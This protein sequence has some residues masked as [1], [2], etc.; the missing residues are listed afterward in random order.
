MHLNDGTGGK[1]GNLVL[2]RPADVGVKFDDCGSN[3][4]ITQTPQNTDTSIGSVGGAAAD[5]YLYFSSGNIVH[6]A[7]PALTASPSCGVAN[8]GAMSVIE[9][10]PLLTQPDAD[11]AN[12]DPRP[13]CDSPAYTGDVEDPRRDAASLAFYDEAN[14]KGAFGNFNWLYGWSAISFA[15]TAPFECEGGDIVGLVITP[16]QL[17]PTIIDNTV[18]VNQT[19]TVYVSAPPAAPGTIMGTGSNGAA[20]ADGD[21]PGWGIG[22]FV[23]LAFLALCVGCTLFLVVQRERVGKPI[24]KPLKE[25]VASATKSSTTG[26]SNAEIKGQTNV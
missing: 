17:P 13:A 2:T 8:T 18:Y 9:S 16:D 24:F 12:P 1:F 21:L 22:V 11:V 5:G 14:F 19:T 6:G 23:I 3:L 15:A 20:S 25:N 10:D 4:L 7:S 26:T